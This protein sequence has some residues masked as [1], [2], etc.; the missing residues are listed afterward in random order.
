[1][2]GRSRLRLS[3][4]RFHFRGPAGQGVRLRGR[5]GLLE[6]GT[7][8][9]LLR[10]VVRRARV[11]AGSYRLGGLRRLSRL[12]FGLDRFRFGGGLGRLG[13]CCRRRWRYRLRFCR[14]LFSLGR[15]RLGFGCC[16]GFG[17]RLRLSFLLG[18]RLVCLGRGLL[19][20]S[21]AGCAAAGLLSGWA[22][23]ASA[24]SALFGWAL[25]CACGLASAA[26]A[27][28]GFSAA[29]GWAW[30][31]FCSAVALPGSCSGTS[32]AG[33]WLSAPCIW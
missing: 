31:G 5:L 29:F 33:G 26:G 22:G 32:L 16:I 23:A 15:F 2:L 20:L 25:A 8:R 12:F 4:N 14:L 9:M 24:C 27:L 7:R 10:L 18:R 28:V 30:A 3:G 17:F 1:M 11:V 6:P 21:A 19:C 13:V